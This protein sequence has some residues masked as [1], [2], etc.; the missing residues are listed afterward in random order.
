[1]RLALPHNLAQGCFR[2]R[3]NDILPLMLPPRS[4]L[5]PPRLL[6]WL[7]PGR[8]GSA[9]SPHL[10]KM[11]TPLLRLARGDVWSLRDAYEGVA[12]FGGIGSGKTTVARLL[13]ELLHGYV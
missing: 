4:T 5:L 10:W 8:P 1:M 3:A 7:S 12:I 9:L 11:D 13:G 6:R 2:K